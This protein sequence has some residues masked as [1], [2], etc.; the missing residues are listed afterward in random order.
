MLGGEGAP[1]LLLSHTSQTRQGTAKAIGSVPPPCDP[2]LNYSL[3]AHAGSKP[4][5]CH[6]CLLLNLDATSLEPLPLPSNLLLTAVHSAIA[7]RTPFSKYNTESTQVFGCLMQSSES[8]KNHA[9][10]ALLTPYSIA[11]SSKTVAQHQ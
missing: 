1:E 5:H 9:S 10:C 4:T 8:H 6:C 2:L 3:P 7:C 11:A